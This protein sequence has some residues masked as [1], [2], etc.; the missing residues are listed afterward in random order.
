MDYWL[1][2]ATCNVVIVR[3]MCVIEYVRNLLEH[4]S[5]QILLRE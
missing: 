2:D 5:S 4:F 1:S 3:E